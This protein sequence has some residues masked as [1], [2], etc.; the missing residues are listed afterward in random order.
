MT[1]PSP[2]RKRRIKIAASS[3]GVKIAEKALIRLGFD[4]RSN[5]AESKRIARNTVTKFFHSE[6]IQVDTFKEICKELKLNWIKI[7]AG[8]EEQSEQ[9]TRNDCSISDI[10]EG[11]EQVETLGSIPLWQK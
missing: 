11:V 4:S 9:I 2:G 7:A 8:I 5:F 3:E 10:N 1:D 6:L